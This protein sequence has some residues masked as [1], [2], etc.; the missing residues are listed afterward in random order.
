MLTAAEFAAQ[1]ALMETHAIQTMIVS[2]CHAK[3]ESAFHA[4][5]AGRTKERKIL[6]AADLAQR[7]LKKKDRFKSALTKIRAEAFPPRLELADARSLRP[8]AAAAGGRA[9]GPG[10]RRDLL[11]R[12]SR[13]AVGDPADQARADRRAGGLQGARDPAGPDAPAGPR[14]HPVHVHHAEAAGGPVREDL[15]PQGGHHAACS[16]AARR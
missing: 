6:T 8:A 12:R 5:M 11:L 7:A 9:P 4:G 2:V 1:H 14:R 13:S 3:M 15:A 10:P 16:A